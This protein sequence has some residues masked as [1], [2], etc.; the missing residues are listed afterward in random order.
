IDTDDLAG[1]PEAIPFLKS[2]DINLLVD[3]SA[4]Q[5]R[6]KTENLTSF[7]AEKELSNTFVVH[8]TITR[9]TPV[10]KADKKAIK[11]IERPIR[12]TEDEH[13]SNSSLE[14]AAKPSFLKRVA[15]W[16]F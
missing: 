16:F 2:S 14:R 10:V 9:K 13:D 4:G 5:S 11:P 8:N 7:A 15:L 3:S 12:N 1:G 6:E